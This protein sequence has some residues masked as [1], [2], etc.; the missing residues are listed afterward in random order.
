M[1]DSGLIQRLAVNSIFFTGPDNLRNPASMRVFR[2]AFIPK[3]Y[4]DIHIIWSQAIGNDESAHGNDGFK[5]GCPQAARVFSKDL[6]KS[7]SLKL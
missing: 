2:L 6:I 1:L 7:G 3:N 5:G 4:S